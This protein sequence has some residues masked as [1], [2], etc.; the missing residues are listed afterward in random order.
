MAMLIVGRDCHL[1]PTITSQ[2]DLPDFIKRSLEQRL[3]PYIQAI[4]LY[5]YETNKR[6]KMFVVGNTGIQIKNGLF[7]DNYY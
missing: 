1:S 6:R 3:I 4:K 7:F 5:G 2:L